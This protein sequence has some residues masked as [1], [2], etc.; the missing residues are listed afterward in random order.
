MH[1]MMMMMMMLALF[2]LF[3]PR[4]DI[5]V[6]VCLRYCIAWGN[7]GSVFKMEQKIIEKL[8]G[9]LKILL[10]V[11]MENAKIFFFLNFHS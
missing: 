8:H 10:F 4:S 3:Y 1:L 9:F 11:T 6:S 2:F 7:L 5:Y